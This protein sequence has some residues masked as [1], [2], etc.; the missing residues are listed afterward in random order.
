M[1]SILTGLGRAA[2]GGCPYCL[3]VF[4]S[5]VH[6][7]YSEFAGIF[8]FVCRAFSAVNV[9]SASKEER[10]ETKKERTG[11][12]FENTVLSK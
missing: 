11:C 4:S 3:D 6:Y 9:W 12:L 1:A 10:K 5:L 2:V 7:A 8:L